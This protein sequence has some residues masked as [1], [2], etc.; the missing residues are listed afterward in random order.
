MAD[1]ASN[2]ENVWYGRGQHGWT[3]FNYDQARRP[4]A[5]ND[6]NKELY[7]NPFV[8]SSRIFSV[9]FIACII[10]ADDGVIVTVAY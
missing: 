1:G 9:R 10:F 8:C 2:S 3:S 7:K 4:D 6:F 5:G